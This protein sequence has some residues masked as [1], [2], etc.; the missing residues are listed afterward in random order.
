MEPHLTYSYLTQLQVLPP[1]LYTSSDFAF[2]VPRVLEL[3]YTARDLDAW[4]RDLGHD[5]PPFVWDPERR[6]LL[7]AE[8]DAYY[9]WLYGLTRGELRYVLD[10]KDVMGEDLPSETFRVL[11]ENDTRRY[12]LVDGMWRTQRLVLEAWDRFVADGTFDP[13]RD[14]GLTDHEK[15]KARLARKIRELEVA[16]ALVAQVREQQRPVLFVEGAS[17]LPIIEAAWSAFFPDEKLPVTILPAGGTTQMDVLAGQGKALQPLLGEK[18]VLVLVDADG[19]GRKLAKGKGLGQG[20]AFRKQAS[21]LWW[22]ILPASPEMATIMQRLGVPPE[23]WPVT[24]EQ[25]FSSALRRA[26]TA[27]GAYAVGKG[28]IALIAVILEPGGMDGVGT[29]MLRANSMM[30]AADHTPEPREEALGVI[31]MGAVAAVGLGVV[32]APHGEARHQQI[33]VR[34]LVRRDDRAGC[35]PFPGEADAL[36]L[37]QEGSGQRSPAALTQGDDNAPFVAAMLEQAAIDPI[38]ACVGGADM[39]AECGTVQLDGTEEH[40]VA[41]LRRHGLA[42]LVHQHE[43]GLVLHVEITGELDGREALGRIHDQADRGQEIDE[44]KFVRG[45]DRA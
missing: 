18:R 37:A 6:A 39:A 5:G 33:P 21:G 31:G 38:L 41:G 36:G 34:D 4:A 44:G 40:N 29:E 15:D 2:V 43:G 17:D 23:K 14:G 42:Q 1:D 27:E 35:R 24:I 10:P 9:G 7:R 16:E 22:S 26:A 32:D 30:L 3:A 11:K 8:L 19:E 13:E 12:G 25:M 20:G 28:A 45:E